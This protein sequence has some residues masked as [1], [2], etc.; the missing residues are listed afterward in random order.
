MWE[1]AYTYWSPNSSEQ[2][3]NISSELRDVIEVVLYF[4]IFRCNLRFNIVACY[5]NRIIRIQQECE[6]V[7]KF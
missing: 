6:I 4:L 7:L 5:S 1:N 3:N 2:R